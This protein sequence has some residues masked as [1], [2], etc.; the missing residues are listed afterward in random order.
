MLFRP[1]IADTLAT[2]PR[3]FLPSSA[4]AWIIT[5]LSNRKFVYIPFVYLR[6]MCR[7]DVSQT[8]P[9]DAGVTVLKDSP[10]L[11]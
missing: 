11:A 9:K 7:A 5:C 1:I 4:S 10:R 3:S 6:L 2:E 8:E